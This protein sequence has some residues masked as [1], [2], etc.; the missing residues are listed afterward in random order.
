MT[1]N[2][3]GFQGYNVHIKEFIENGN[4]IDGVEVVGYRPLATSEDTQADYLNWYAPFKKFMPRFLKDVLAFISNFFEYRHAVKRVKEESPDALVFRHNFMNFYQILLQKR[5]KLP[6]LLE[7]NSPLT[8]ERKKQKEV[9][10]GFLS[11]WTEL[12]S[13]RAADI[14]YTVS[15]EL[16]RMLAEHVDAHKIVAIHNGANV[17]DYAG[18]V[19]KPKEKVRIGFLGS[20]RKYHGIDVL[21]EVIPKVLDSYDNVEFYMVGKGGSYEYYK[22]YF[23]DQPAYKERV[24]MVGNVPYENVPSELVN[25]DISMML[26]FTEY[27][28]PLKMFEYMMAKTAMLLPDRKT[29]RE[30]VVDGEDAM[31]FT[32]RDP[33]DFERA[34]KILIEDSELRNSIAQNAYNKVCAEYTWYNN[35]EKIVA[36]LKS[37][38]K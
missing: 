17:D 4:K 38:S 26:D 23:D 5:F 16:K 19:K 7:V 14:V 34:I 25:F 6:L 18:L 28:S 3:E 29:I 31:L 36:A 8:Y 15:G 11:W 2:Y 35:A 13:W 9:T 10:L 27:G 1:N 33:A 32:P 30:V 22:N 20:F 24:L 12:A 37:V 21:F